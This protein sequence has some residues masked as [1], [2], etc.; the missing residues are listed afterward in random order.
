MDNLVYF[1]EATRIFSTSLGYWRDNVYIGS[2][3]SYGL[4]ATY[5]YL[6]RKWKVN[7]AY[8]LCHDDVLTADSS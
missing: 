5:K 6:A 3:R 4:E 8:T 7:V 1:M 2:G